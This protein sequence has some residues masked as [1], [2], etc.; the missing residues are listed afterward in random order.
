MWQ[1]SIKNSGCLMHG[2]E[3]W[4][5]AANMHREYSDCATCGFSL[6]EDGRRKK[7]PLT[8]N[9][10]GYRRKVISTYVGEENECI[11]QQSGNQG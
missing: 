3:K 9:R 11:F 10:Y 4:E 1:L 2:C 5:H 7:I 8:L 6:K